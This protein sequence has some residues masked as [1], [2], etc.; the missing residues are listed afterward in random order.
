[1]NQQGQMRKVFVTVRTER[2]PTRESLWASRV[3]DDAVRI[4]NTPHLSHTADA[5]GDAL[6]EVGIGKR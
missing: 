4:A 5:L 3:T 1:M 6:P 2:G